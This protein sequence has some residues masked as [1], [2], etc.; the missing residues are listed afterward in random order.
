M[1]RVLEWKDTGSLGRVG[2]GDEGE[3]GVSPHVSD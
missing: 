2:M 3:E 1:T